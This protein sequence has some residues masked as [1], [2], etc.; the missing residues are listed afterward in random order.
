[1]FANNEIGTLQPIAEIARICKEKD[2]FFHVDAAQAAGKI[3]LNVRELGIDLLAFSAHKMYGPKGIAALYVRKAS[4]R[5]RLE[6]LLH[7]GGHEKSLRSGTSNV[8]GIVGLAKA[9]EIAQ[10][11]MADD[12]K[13]V[14]ALRDQFYETL[15]AALPDLTL[16]GDPVNRL[17]NN[18]NITFPDVDSQSLVMSLNEKIAVSSGSAC[19]SRSPEPSYVLKSLGLRE[20]SIHQSIRFGFGKYTTEAEIQTAGEHVLSVVRKLRKIAPFRTVDKS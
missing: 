9:C 14:R 10:A 20:Q 12:E 2:V 19:I 18:L 8:P 11:E 5:V 16:N 3:P 13:R 4:P 7:G 17:Y 15:R 6:P 1:M